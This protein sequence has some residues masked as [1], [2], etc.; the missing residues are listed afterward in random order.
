VRREH[1]GGLERGKKKTIE[2]AHRR[3]AYS[4]LQRDRINKGQGGEY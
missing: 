4:K 1:I 2:N 3:E